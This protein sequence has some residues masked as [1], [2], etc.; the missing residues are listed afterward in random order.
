M[1]P[2]WEVGLPASLPQTAPRISDL[3][4]QVQPLGRAWRHVGSLRHRCTAG[5]ED[6]GHRSSEKKQA[7]TRHGRANK[8]RPGAM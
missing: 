7:Q 1:T 8:Y 6:A 5:V 2:H 3:P 4:T